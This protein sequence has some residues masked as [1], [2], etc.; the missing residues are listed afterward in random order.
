MLHCVSAF[1]ALPMPGVELMK[2]TANDRRV[3]SIE[4]HY[5]LLSRWRNERVCLSCLIIDH[6]GFAM[7]MAVGNRVA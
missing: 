7:V 2:N 1:L 5:W 4:S 3:F 6:D